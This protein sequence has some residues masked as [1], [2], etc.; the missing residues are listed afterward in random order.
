LVDLICISTS[1]ADVSTTSLTR[2]L[3]L[4]PF[5]RTAEHYLF[6]NGIPNPPPGYIA[7]AGASQYTWP[8]IYK[9]LQNIDY[10]SDN[11]KQVSNRIH[12]MNAFTV[13]PQLP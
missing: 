12:C 11:F 7:P 2:T 10:C 4:F 9:N 13:G 8:A 5:R 3:S 1:K 6:F